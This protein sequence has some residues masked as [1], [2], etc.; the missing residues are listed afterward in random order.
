M[1]LEEYLR[2]NYSKASLTSYEN[3]INRYRAFTQNAETASYSDVMTYIKYL[4]RKGNHPKT[5]RNNLFAI[6]IYYRYLIKTGKRKD[7]PCSELNLKDSINRSIPVEELYSKEQLEELLTTYK[8]KKKNINERNKVIISLLIYQALT[9]LE[10][11][12]ININDIN[13]EEGTIFISGNVK[14]NC[15]T[16]NLKTNQIMLLHRYITETRPKL[17]NVERSE[18][19]I[20]ERIGKNSALIISS[21]GERIKPHSISRLINDGLP[22][23]KRKTPI[24]IRQSV[25]ANLLKSGN[26]LRIVQV[27]A[28]HKRVS[29]TEAYKQTGLDEL[30]SAITKLHPLQ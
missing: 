10:I 9:V 15:R 17:G 24:K 27:F 22:K 18:I 23:S 4:R 3:M 20:A 12:Q 7:H 11:S 19:P 2:K 21:T 1:K 29:S 25:I 13:L 5:V 6:K 30:K 8:T 16:L 26:E 14:N 28:G